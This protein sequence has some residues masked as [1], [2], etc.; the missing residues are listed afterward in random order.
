[1]LTLTYSPFAPLL[2]K[3]EYYPTEEKEMHT[4]GSRKEETKKRRKKG[5]L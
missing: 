3:I 5:E 2:K 4:L 1:V